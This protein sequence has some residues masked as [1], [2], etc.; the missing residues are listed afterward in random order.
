MI[1]ERFEASQEK[2][3]YSEELENTLGAREMIDN[4]ERE[5]DIFLQDQNKEIESK[6]ELAVL[7]LIKL[8]IYRKQDQLQSITSQS[9]LSG[10][11][12]LTLSIIT[13][14]LAKRKGYDVKIGRPDKLSRYFHALIIKQDGEIFKVAGK[15]RKYS[16]KEMKVDDVVSRLKSFNPIIGVIDSAKKYF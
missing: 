10:F 12:C 5:F 3:S 13:S 15:N 4:I 6:N 2:L 1:L 14:L 7:R 16:A 9:I 11:D 8:F